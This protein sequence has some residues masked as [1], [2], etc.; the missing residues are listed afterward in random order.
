MSGRFIAIAVLASA[1]ATEVIVAEAGPSPQR[2]V[3]IRVVAKGQPN[4]ASS[5]PRLSGDGRFVAFTSKA[6]NLAGNPAPGV[7]NTYLFDQN[8][9][10][11]RLISRGP[12]GARAKGPSVTPAVTSD[13]KEVVFA[14]RASNLAA[15][16]GGKHSDVFAWT[17]A[18]GIQLVSGAPA[19]PAPA[20]AARA[21]APPAEAP[22]PAPL[23]PSDG[24]S[25]QPDVSADG[26]LVVFSSGA[27]NLVDGD[28]NKRRDVFVRDTMAG[29]TYR[30]ST[31]RDGVPA[32]GDSSAPSISPDGRFV[33]FYSR[34]T[35]LLERRVR[36]RGD[37]YLRDLIAQK[38]FLVSV[39]GGP[40]GKEQNAAVAAPFVQVSSV[41]AD[42]R[43]VAFDSDATNLVTHDR[44]HDTD[45]F[46]RDML[47]GGIR[48]ASLAT[49]DQESDSDSFAPRI[50]SNGRFVTFESFAHNL[51]PY[52]PAG[53]NIFVR[54]LTRNTTVMAEVSGRGRPRNRER[55]KQLL[56]RPSISD[57]GA[58]VAF[59]STAT[60]LVGHDTRGV[61]DVF[62]RRLLPT[63][64]TILSQN[65]GV[66]NGHLVL[67]FMSSDASAGPLLC[68]IDKAPK[69][70]CP[71][72]RTVLPRFHSGRHRVVAYPG[73]IGTAYGVKPIVVRI[74]MRHG[75][76][77]VKVINPGGQ[78]G[79]G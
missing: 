8:K 28:T 53:P 72:G 73:G 7:S 71:L 32:N 23:G 5:E 1:L 36:S 65:V 31:G 46:V 61:Q 51:V 33:S 6:T 66:S 44:N 21:A 57:D 45:V 62:L 27:T 35:N 69:A 34:A 16:G 60:N 50:T 38:T 78:L 77:R 63:P 9:S 11:L 39:S 59:S 68:Q 10:Y 74:T 2:T 20:P 29:R 19:A 76:A 13:G 47:T 70:L 64:L 30:V 55:V 40:T 58:T 67:N 43:F 15:G 17:E 12:K 54:D 3:R 22:A 49:T 79:L 14:S 26:R 4:G 25:D 24:D 37:V 52:Q 48:R 75:R 42:G 56:Q 18:G 41:S